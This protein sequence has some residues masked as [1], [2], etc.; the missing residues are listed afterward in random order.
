MPLHRYV[1]LARL[2]RASKQLTGGEGQRVTEIALDAGHE[3]PDAFAAP[4]DRGSGS[5]RRVLGSPPNGSRGS[6]PSGN[7]NARRISIATYQRLPWPRRQR[8]RRIEA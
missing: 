8:C 1:Q 3:T 7:S 5:R 4:F 6:G 2:K